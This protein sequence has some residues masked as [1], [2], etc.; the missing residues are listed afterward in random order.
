MPLASVADV[1]EIEAADRLAGD[2]VRLTPLRKQQEVGA[3]LRWTAGIVVDRSVRDANVDD[4][5]MDRADLAACRL[6]D[7]QVWVLPEP[8]QETR[9]RSSERADAFPVSGF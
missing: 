1:G 9:A 5:S 2:P 4:T 6:G 3:G 7:R 8:G